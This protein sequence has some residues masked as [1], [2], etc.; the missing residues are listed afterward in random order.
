L[1]YLVLKPIDDENGNKSS[2]TINFKGKKYDALYLETIAKV[3]SIYGQA[4][5]TVL[6]V[7]IKKIFF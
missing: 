3:K 2:Q 6:F 1:L 4:W 5:S 7:I